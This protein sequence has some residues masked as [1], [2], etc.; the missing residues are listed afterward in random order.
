MRHRHCCFLFLFLLKHIFILF[1][2]L[3]V[4]EPAQLSLSLSLS[5]SFSNVSELYI[6]LQIN[7]Y[8]RASTQT[9]TIWVFSLC[10]SYR[11]PPSAFR[12]KQNAC[13][14]A[15]NEIIGK[16]NKKGILDPEWSLFLCSFRPLQ[17]FWL[18]LF[19]VNQFTGYYYYL[20]R[21]IE[22]ADNKKR[23]KKRRWRRRLTF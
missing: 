9:E 22:M 12:N 5:L 20:V 2:Y 10:G 21:L 15:A 14:V 17:C 11:R 6:L 8:D 13:I 23:K 1:H 16:E 3:R 18:Y 19:R 4:R 7:K